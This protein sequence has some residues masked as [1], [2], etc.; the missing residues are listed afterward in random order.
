MATSFI[1][2][3]V[4]K[5]LFKQK[6]AIA[7]NKAV[8]FS[9]N[10]LETRLKNFGVDVNAI[11]NEKQLNEIL[12]II[13]Q[14]ED[15][16]FAQQFGDV[17]KRRKSADVFDLKGKKI[18][19]TDNI[20]GGEELPPPG[21]RGGKDDIA[22]PFSSQEETMSNMIKDELM[23]TDNAFS[24]LVKTTEKG[25][26]TLKEREAEILARMEKDNKETVARI[27]N[28]KMVKDAVDNVSPGFVKGDRKYNAQLVA[29]DLAEK[30]FGKDF[31]DLDQK[32]Q[33]DLYSQALDGLSVDP[34][35]FAT[36]GRAGFKSGLSKLFK[37]FMDRRK[38]LKTMVGNTEKNKRARELEM[39]KKA[40]ED[41]RKNPGFEFPSGQE[42]RTDIEKKIGPILLKD[43][44]LNSDGGRA[45]FRSGS[46]KG[47]MEFFKNMIKPK[48][49]RMFD[50]ERFRKGPIDMD[51]L[52]NI[53]KK[54][55][56]KF[57]TTRDT[58]GVGGFGMYDNL[59]DMPA[60]LRAAELI[61]TIKT[62]DG[63]INYKAAELF[64]GKKLRGDESADELIQILNR[65]EMRAEGGRIGYADGTPS[66]EEYMQERQ[67]IEKKE[68]FER[69]YK[70]YL[71][72]LRRKGVMEQKQEAKDG[73]R[74]GLKDGMDRRTFLKI[75][76]GLAS[77]PILG[78]FF[79]GAKVVSKAAPVAKTVSKSEPPP[80]FFELAET[81]KKF[82]RVSDGPQERIKIHSMPAK[83]GK[84]EL[85]LTEDIGTGE[86]QI[87]KISKENDEMVTEVQTMDYAPSSA[88]SDES[89][90]VA[91]QYDE[92]TEYNSRIYKDEY[93]E[94]DIV[95]GIKVDEIIDEVKEAPSIKKAA[96]G[97]ARMLGE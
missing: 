47:I 77:I 86:M 91:S 34:D 16:M 84:S 67:G 31:Y 37:E 11:Q 97:I 66:F 9:A 45:G 12:A 27:R 95:D 48:K 94:P 61:K 96:G 87:K 42:L 38:F 51:F 92:Y 30:K 83:D 89:G 29:E 74:I 65:Q 70:E 78:K 62:K 69:L 21:S 59:A 63:G 32:Q 14:R 50:E 13:K 24:D 17:L 41:A 80:Y 22:A 46:G 54:D 88:L 57:I 79:K 36:G 19:N 75:M 60:G 6:G 10:A 18:K 26:K 25:P 49:S 53:D 71:E 56:E 35:K 3:F 73:G 39:L 1:K 72:D 44:K 43:R 15:D 40:M 55:L 68:N 90:K 4:A 93:N 85:M 81:I 33:S 7:N 28:R 58:G 2:N 23:K 8:D 52:E 76:G 5:A 82:G 20:M 64:L